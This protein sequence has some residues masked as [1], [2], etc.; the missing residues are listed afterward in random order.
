MDAKK[1]AVLQQLKS[2][3]R[4]KKISYQDIA[5][6]TEEMGEAVSLTTVKR[7]FAE[8]SRAEDFRY[9]S[10]IR[11]IV[12]F[13][14]GIEGTLEEPQT[15]EEAR[16][17]S[18][19]LASVVDLKD[20]MLTRMGQDLD[21]QREDFQRQKD[22]LKQE[23]ATARRERDEAQRQVQ[24]FRWLIYGLLILLIICLL[25]VIVYLMLDRSNPSW[26]IFWRSAAS[27]LA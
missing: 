14:A 18:E 16:A 19:T 10:T 23:L 22:F 15:F 7:V 4:A 27:S 24:R 25:L 13:L 20:A 21:R 5:D 2:L 6:G 17:N 3:R 9:D 26:G 1:E 8:N 12:R 11:P